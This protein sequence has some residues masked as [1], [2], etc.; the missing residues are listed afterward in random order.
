MGNDG[1]GK[2]EYIGGTL[3]GDV[4]TAEVFHFSKYAVL[5]L[6]R[7]FADVKEGHWATAAIKS[8]AAKHI[9]TGMQASPISLLAN[10]MP[11]TEL[12]GLAL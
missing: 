2:L 11:H 10:G 4:M 6:D 7:T 8:L 12:A 1:K 9:L 3:N 5:V